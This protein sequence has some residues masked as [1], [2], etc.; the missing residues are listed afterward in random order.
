MSPLVYT[1]HFANRVGLYGRDIDRESSKHIPGE[2]R[3]LQFNRPIYIINKNFVTNCV[4]LWDAKL[5]K[6]KNINQNCF[7]TKCSGNVFGNK[8][9]MRKANTARKGLLHIVTCEVTRHGVWIGNR[10]NRLVQ[11]VTTINYRAMGNFR[12]LEF[13]AA[14]TKTFQSAVSAPFVAW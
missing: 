10:I 13:T 11:I 5:L 12:T 6:G 14:R 9:Q 4:W 1:L 8:R 7:K 2:E 3:L